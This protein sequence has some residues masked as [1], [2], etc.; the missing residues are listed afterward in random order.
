MAC[1]GQGGWGGWEG[2][3]LQVTKGLVLRGRGVRGPLS[4]GKGKALLG[5]GLL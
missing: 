1:E 2:E 5:L 3:G 4:E